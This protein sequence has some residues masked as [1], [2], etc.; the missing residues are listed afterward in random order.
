MF[1]KHETTKPAARNGSK[2]QPTPPV[3]VAPY[4][5]G[6]DLEGIAEPLERI[7]NSL[8]SYNLNA[9]AGDNALQVFSDKHGQPVRVV[10]DC[11]DVA[12]ALNRIA[13]ALEGKA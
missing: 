1:P 6:I 7:A 3:D 11:P 13:A 5:P 8:K 2:K 9:T 4:E 12:A 10:L